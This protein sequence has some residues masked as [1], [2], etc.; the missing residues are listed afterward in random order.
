M[1]RCF[2]K[3]LKNGAQG[4][5]WNKTMREPGGFVANRIGNI[6]VKQASN[7]ILRAAIHRHHGW[8]A[9]SW[10][11]RE[12]S[13]TLPQ[14]ETL[15]QNDRG[16]RAI[17]GKRSTQN[18]WRICSWCYIQYWGHWGQRVASGMLRC[19][20]PMWEKSPRWE[21]FAPNGVNSQGISDKWNT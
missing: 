3:I 17:S 6:Q 15:E 13:K 2:P 20:A 14:E 7:N 21:R 10:D 8:W 5:L 11:V 18:P 1:V 16:T 19:K 9:R 4:Q 12:I